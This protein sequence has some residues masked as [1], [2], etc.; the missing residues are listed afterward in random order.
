MVEDR[1]GRRDRIAAEE[2]RQP[3][4]LRAR[5]QADRDRLGAGD[6]AVE[7]RL[8]RRRI[9]MVLG[10]LAADL[11]RL[12]I[13][14]ARRSAPR[15]WLPQARAPWRTWCAAT[16]DR[17]PVAVEHPEREAER[18]HIL[19]TQGFLVAEPE[20]LHS[21]HRQLADIQGDHLPLRK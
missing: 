10:D 12:A 15:Y 20:G 1:A 7:A 8:G 19:G 14:M 11:R 5:D 21:I 9:D 13:S 3:C 17:L 18:P 2:H 16:L 6:G 4:K